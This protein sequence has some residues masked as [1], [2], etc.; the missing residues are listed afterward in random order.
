M[1]RK[2]LVVF[3]LSLIALFASAQGVDISLKIKGLKDTSVILGYHYGSQKYV[4]DTIAINGA[5]EGFVKADTLLPGGIYLVIVPGNTY[6]EMLISSDQKFSVTTDKSN[7]SENLVFKGSEENSKFIE[8]QKYMVSKQTESKKYRDR[9]NALKVRGVK[10]SVDY[11]LKKLD[12][13]DKDISEYWDKL[14]KDNK[15]TFFANIIKAMKFPTIPEFVIPNHIVNKDSMRWVMG[16]NYNKNHYLDG[17]DFTDERLLRTP[18]FQGK[19]E[20]YFSRLLL[21]IPDSLK[22]EVDHIVELSETNRKVQQYVLVF[23][24]DYYNKT[25]L[26]GLDE[27]FVYVA[28][29]YYLSGKAWWITDDFKQKLD[30]RVMKIKPT[31]LGRKAPEIEAPMLS[32]EPTSLWHTD[33]RFTIL[34]FYDPDCGHC[35][36]AIPALNKVYQEKYAHKDVAVFAMN[37]HFEFE[38]WKTFIDK[39]NLNWINVWDPHKHSH[40]HT[41]YDVSYT[42]IMFLLDRDKKI[43]AKKI[44]LEDLEKILDNELK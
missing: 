4:T 27:M 18:V 33:A 32:G 3:A 19:V 40:F 11:F 26:M 34:T 28:E 10:D 20:H 2:G 30:E 35:K 39:N 42:P 29:K 6:F 17:L 14:I 12:E 25:E 36:T 37:T 24:L 9:L 7:L 23:L 15:G 13:L 1:I 43:I 21:Q 22:K 41:N 8:Y 16:Y 31:L 38:K 5:G 44:S